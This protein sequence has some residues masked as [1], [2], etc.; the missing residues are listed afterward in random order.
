MFNRERFCVISEGHTHAGRE[1][2]IGDVIELRPGLA[3]QYPNTFQREGEALRTTPRANSAKPKRQSGSRG[4][5]KPTP[6]E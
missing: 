5:S 2:H 6:Q 3:E 4:A 1:L